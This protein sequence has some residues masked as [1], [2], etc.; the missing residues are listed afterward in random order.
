[1]HRLKQFV[2]QVPLQSITA[3]AVLILGNEKEVQLTHV[4]LCKGNLRE[5]QE[6]PRY[7]VLPQLERNDQRGSHIKRLASVW[8]ELCEHDFHKIEPPPSH[9]Q[10]KQ[11][12][13]KRPMVLGFNLFEPRAPVRPGTTRRVKRRRPQALVASGHRLSFRRACDWCLNFIISNFSMVHNES[14]ATQ[15]RERDGC[16]IK[17]VFQRALRLHKRDAFEAFVLLIDLLELCA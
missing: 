1:M 7:R 12:L 6:P 8:P 16:R 2:I 13:V 10:H 17:A 11:L 14:H 9:G 4:D 15:S 5:L 3:W